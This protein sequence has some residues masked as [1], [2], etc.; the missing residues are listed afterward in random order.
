MPNITLDRLMTF[1]TAYGDIK[2]VDRSG[3]T[4]M[5]QPDVPDVFDLIAKADRFW[6]G[7]KWHSREGFLRILERAESADAE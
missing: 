1:V 7:E 4:I 3:K 2:I 5:L 6:Y